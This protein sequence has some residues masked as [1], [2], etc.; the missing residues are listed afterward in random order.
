MLNCDNELQYRE[1]LVHEDFTTDITIKNSPPDSLPSVH[2][3]KYLLI[4]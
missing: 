1:E 2:P 4:L 3:L